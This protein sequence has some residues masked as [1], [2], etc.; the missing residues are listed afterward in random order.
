MYEPILDNIF[1][2]PRLGAAN[3]PW[4][5]VVKAGQV[6][7][8]DAYPLRKK[9]IQNSGRKS[10]RSKQQGIIPRKCSKQR[11]CET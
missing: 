9:R 11:L 1:I 5:D 6:W 2:M 7:K 3:Q 10:T 8:A 4:S